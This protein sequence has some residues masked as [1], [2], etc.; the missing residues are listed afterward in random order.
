M[1]W[2][3]ML[4]LVIF[5]TGGLPPLHAAPRGTE[6]M[7]CR[8]PNRRFVVHFS[9]PRSEG[10][11]ALWGLVSVRDLRSGQARIVRRAAGRRGAGH[12]EGF[13]PL[14]RPDAWSPDGLFLAYTNAFCTDAPEAP[15]GI[16]CHLHDIR[17]LSVRPLPPH[18][19]TLSLGRYAFGGWKRPHT[20][21]EILVNGDGRS[22]PRNPTQM[23]GTRRTK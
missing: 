7:T 15:G 21:L 2:L 1:P 23:T 3:T 13:Q 17:V 12:F 16:V 6:T 18:T 22:V 5:L 20:V 14:D 11:D 10:P 19:A 9:Q 4:L 8:S